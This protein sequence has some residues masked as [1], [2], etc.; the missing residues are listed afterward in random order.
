M[1]CQL[2]IKNFLRIVQKNCDSH[3]SQKKTMILI[4]NSIKMFVILNIEKGE[5]VAFV[6]IS[7]GVE[8]QKII[9][10]NNIIG[11]EYEPPAYIK[12]QIFRIAYLLGYHAE[13]FSKNF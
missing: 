10:E 12:K 4:F 8:S 9:I 11:Y 5:D 6:L 13:D 1:N 7:N 2:R 3:D